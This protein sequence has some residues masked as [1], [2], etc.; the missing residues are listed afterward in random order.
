MFYRRPCVLHSQSGAPLALDER[1]LDLQPLRHLMVR[2]T[3]PSGPYLTRGSYPF[4]VIEVLLESDVA[5]H[6]MIESPPREE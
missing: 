2:A 3:E 5:F 4:C 1:Q 6:P